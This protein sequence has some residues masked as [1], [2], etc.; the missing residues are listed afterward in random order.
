MNTLVAAGRAGMPLVRAV[1]IGV[2]MMCAIVAAE[3][4]KPTLHLSE[5]R[6]AIKLDQQVPRGFGDWVEDTS[7]VPVLPD[8]TLQASLDALYS[9]VLARTYVNRDGQRVMLAIAYGSDQSSEA[10]SVH[11]P[12]FCY[13]AQ[14][15]RVRGA[16]I[17]TVDS[18]GGPLRVQRLVAQIGQRVEPITYWVTLDDRATLPGL[19]RK[20]EQLRFG[21]RGEIADGML[22]RVSSIGADE[23]AAFKLQDSFIRDL[24]KALPP[25]IRHRYFGRETQ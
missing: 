21:F 18:Q 7:M 20:I 24:R 8:P 14:G 10:T 12:E 11:R 19:G 25:D 2:I 17:A 23:A 15:F 22:V 4:M 13:S 9:Q 16:G 6:P 3:V 1:A 5:V